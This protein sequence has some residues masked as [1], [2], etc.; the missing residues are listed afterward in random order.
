MN[1][2]TEIGATEADVLPLIR[3]AI[4]VWAERQVRAGASVPAPGDREALVQAVYEQRYGDRRHRGRRPAADQ[5]R[6]P[7]LGRAAG[8]GRSLGPGAGRP[9]G[10]RPGCL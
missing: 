1:S 6:D 7:G 5:G 3:D 10:A 2:A 9:R 4:R 8:P